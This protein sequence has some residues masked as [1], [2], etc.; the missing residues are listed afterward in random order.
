MQL[1][2]QEQYITLKCTHYLKQFGFNI[3]SERFSDYDKVEI[4]KKL[5]ECHSTNTKALEL[6]VYICIG[7]EVYLPQIWNGVLKQMVSL[8]MVKIIGKIFIEN[9]NLNFL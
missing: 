7:Y 6:I 2:S 8:N 9:N 4:L 1:L 5:W 3:T